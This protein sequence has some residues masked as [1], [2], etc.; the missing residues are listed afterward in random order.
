MYLNLPENSINVA[1]PDPCAMLPRTL[2]PDIFLGAGAAWLSS[3][4]VEPSPAQHC[5]S[6][7]FQVWLMLLPF[8]PAQ[9]SRSPSSHAAPLPAQHFRDVP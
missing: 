1:V 6:E 4:H 3:S 9:D 5:H 2:L 7:W 8:L